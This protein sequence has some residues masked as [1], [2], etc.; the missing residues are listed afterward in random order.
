M[1]CA[2]HQRESTSGKN[3]QV[4]WLQ[5][6]EL[7][8]ILNGSLYPKD[9]SS[10]K[11]PISMQG[12]A[13]QNTNKFLI[14]GTNIAGSLKSQGFLKFWLSI[15]QTNSKKMYSIICQSLFMLKD[16]V[17][18]Q[19]PMQTRPWPSL[20]THSMLWKTSKEGLLN[21]SNKGLKSKLKSMYAM[22]KTKMN[23]TKK[24]DSLSNH[25]KCIHNLLIASSSSISTATN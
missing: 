18:M 10:L 12:Q 23:K 8:V 16:T 7:L 3:C 22:I 19:L 6:T 13:I 11:C 21:F 17:L 20:L 24:K 1:Q 5:L 15:P 4:T 2:T 14:I 25:K 9:L